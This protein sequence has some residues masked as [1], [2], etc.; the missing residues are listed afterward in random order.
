MPESD[1]TVQIGIMVGYVIGQGE[2]V[3]GI[4]KRGLEGIRSRK[5]VGNA[6]IHIQKAPKRL[7]D[8]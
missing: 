1:G 4:V 6:G 2:V 3:L 7:F 5:T 8:Y